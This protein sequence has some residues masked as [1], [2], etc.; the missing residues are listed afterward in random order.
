MGLAQTQVYGEH[1]E[2]MDVDEHD[3]RIVL[4]L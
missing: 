3:E 1:E 4:T 2:T